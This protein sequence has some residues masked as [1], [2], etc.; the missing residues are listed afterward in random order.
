MKYEDIPDF[1]VDVNEKFGSKDLKII[2]Y[3]A[4]SLEPIITTYG[5]FLN[6][7]DPEVRSDI[8]DRLVQLQTEEIEIKDYKVMNE[9]DYEY[10]YENYIMKI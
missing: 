10:V 2:E 6:K 3:G 9:D 5:M 7:C 4:G 1:I 8:I